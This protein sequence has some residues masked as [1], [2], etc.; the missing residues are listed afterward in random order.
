MAYLP[1]VMVMSDVNAF[2]TYRDGGGTKA[3]TYGVKSTKFFGVVAL[4]NASAGT[5]F[6][7]NWWVGAEFT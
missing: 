2:N 7:F 6:Q 1:D 5:N 3:V 4:N